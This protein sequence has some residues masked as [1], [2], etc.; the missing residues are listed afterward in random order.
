MT[1]PGRAQLLIAALVALACALSAGAPA[2]ADAASPFH[3]LLFV[4]FEGQLWSDGVRF[5]FVT[6]KPVGSPLVFDTLRGRRF[7]LTPP[8]PGCRYG[9]SGGGLTLWHCPPPRQTLISNL[10][11]GRSREPVGIEQV[12]RM[13][14][15]YSFCR[16][17]GIGWHWL[18]LDC[19]GTLG[20]RSDPFYLNHRTGALVQHPSGLYYEHP[21]IDLDYAGLVHDR[22]APLGPS[23][24]RSDPHV[25]IAVYR[26]P[27][28]LEY[29]VKLE[30]GETDELRLRRCGQK[31][32]ELLSRCPD[33]VCVTPQLGGRY[34][35]WG[36]DERVFSYLP[37]IRRRVLVGRAPAE[38][39]GYAG[40]LTVAHTC[41]RVFARWSLDLYVARFK[42][43]AGAP[44]CQAAR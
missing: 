37:R 15:E 31:R 25:Y 38:L 39:R 8:V 7:R 42:P 27:L 36:E 35:T 33:Y 5:A 11:S 41:N 23:L 13:T 9:G 20:P 44:R 34:V 10:A 30:S 28:A 12:D 43:R 22:C 32:A 21:L 2:R 6:D 3:R 19:G 17:Y 4:P 1:R 14:T 18:E 40:E 26:P 29:S 16:P 24:E